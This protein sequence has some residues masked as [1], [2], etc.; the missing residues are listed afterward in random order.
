MWYS[1]FVHVDRI[2]GK[3]TSEILKC[4]TNGLSARIPDVVWDSLITTYRSCEARRGKETVG[5]KMLSHI[6]SMKAMLLVS[7]DCATVLATG[8]PRH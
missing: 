5:L 1:D 6:F 8:S 7:G 4:Q 3:L 2:T